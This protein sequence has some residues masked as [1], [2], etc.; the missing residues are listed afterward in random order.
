MTVRNSDIEKAA[1]VLRAGGLVALP[2]ETVYGLGANAEDP[3]A[4]ARI[5]QTKGRPSSHPL[6]VHIS[7]ADSLDEWVEDVPPTARLLAEHFWPGPLTLVLPRGR[8]VPREATGGLDTVA[9][10]VPAHPVALALLSEFGGGITAPSANRFGS[11]SP[12]TADHVRAE[13]GAAV[14]F[15]L[16]GGPCEVGVESTIVDVTGEVPSILRPGGVTREE[17]EAVL[18]R[19]IAVPATS[20]VRVPGQHPSHYAPRAR[21]ILVEADKLVAEAERAQERGHQVGVF[22]PSGAATPSKVQAVVT[23]PSSLAAYARGLYG[24]LRELDER[25]CDLII[26]SLP[27]E[28]GLGLA[29]A[30]RLRRAAGPRPGADQ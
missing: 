4:V 17:L 24:F 30:N 6:I 21:V 19:P 13:L 27:A 9:V 2:T 14:D 20:S 18:A 7:G 25:G 28:E 29:I 5:F 26:A 15:V 22:L 8:R 16:D 10:R 12:T 23:L 11:V 3:A 1:G